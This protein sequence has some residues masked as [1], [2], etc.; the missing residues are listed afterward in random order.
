MNVTVIACDQNASR[1]RVTRPSNMAA[2]GGLATAN[3]RHELR[4]DLWLIDR[5]KVSEEPKEC[6][7]IGKV[8]CVARH[9]KW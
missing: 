5:K 6:K 8:I 1:C 4:H 7:Q 9:K 2:I 3:K